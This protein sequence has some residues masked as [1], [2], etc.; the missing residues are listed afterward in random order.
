MEKK[1]PWME[2]DLIL[3]I[4]GIGF[5]VAVCST[6][7]SKSG[8]DEQAQYVTLAGIL[9]VMTLLLGGVEDL[10]GTVRSLFGV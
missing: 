2:I 3:K 8:R 4:A 10:I 9:V 5:L 6:V 1:G 7:L